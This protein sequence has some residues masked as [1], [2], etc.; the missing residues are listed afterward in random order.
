LRFKERMSIPNNE[1]IKKMIL[2]EAHKSKLNIHP[3]TKK[4]VLRS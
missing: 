3:G 2:E 4:N 1:E